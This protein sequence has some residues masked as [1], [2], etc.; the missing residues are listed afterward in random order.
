[1]FLVTTADVPPPGYVIRA[2]EAQSGVKLCLD[3][4]QPDPLKWAEGQ[5]PLIGPDRFPWVLSDIALKPRPRL[6][7]EPR[8]P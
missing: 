5:E 8:I 4:Y 3:P 7:L 2:E 1:V 6:A